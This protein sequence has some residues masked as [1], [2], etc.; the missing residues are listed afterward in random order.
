MGD[1]NL[2]SSVKKN[3]ITPFEK[4]EKIEDDVFNYDLVT[5]K[6]FTPLWKASKTNLNSGPK[7]ETAKSEIKEELEFEKCILE[8]DKIGIEK[9]FAKW[10]EDLNLN[11][12]LEGSMEDIEIP[13]TSS[14]D[15]FA[16]SADYLNKNNNS[17]SSQ[18]VLQATSPKLVISTKRVMLQRNISLE[19]GKSTGNKVNLQHL[20]SKHKNILRNRKNNYRSAPT[21]PT[22]KKKYNTIPSKG[23][24][25]LE[26]QSTITNHRSLQRGNRSTNRSSSLSKK[27]S[28]ETFLSN[29]HS[30]STYNT[31]G[32]K[33]SSMRSLQ[34]GGANRRSGGSNLSLISIDSENYEDE[35]KDYRENA[36]RGRK[37]DVKIAQLEKERLQNIVNMC[38]SLMDNTELKDSENA[39]EFKKPMPPAKPARKS[40]SKL[41]INFGEAN[42]NNHFISTNPSNKPPISPNSAKFTKN[43]SVSPV[44]SMNSQLRRLQSFEDEV[45][46][47]S[48]VTSSIFVDGI[49]ELD[50]KGVQKKTYQSPLNRRQADI[51]EIL[52]LRDENTKKLKSTQKDILQQ[53]ELI[54]ESV[55]E[56]GMEKELLTAELN[57]EH[58]LLQKEELS[59]EKIKDKIMHQ[60]EKYHEQRAKQQE[61]VSKEKN[62]LLEI[63]SNVSSIKKQIDKC[64]ESTRGS[65]EDKLNQEEETLREKTTNF[66]DLEFQALEICSKLDESH[67]DQE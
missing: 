10:F 43:S 53:E 46:K 12:A 54:S 36:R 15:I 32:F 37:N 3:N 50:A 20:R 61:I 29:N 60:A 51:E 55:R 52:R 11:S 24:K 19:S 18:Q 45:I 8:N 23:E 6:L 62:R 63:E 67:Q 5:D 22:T 57:D 30:D 4:T 64:P 28:H 17:A 59:C 56:N 49:H 38:A 16:C 42:K 39:S 34:L 44:S 31:L 35:L 21:S 7:V 2:T 66:E 40:I 47:D 14:A 26:L 41:N 33:A 1:T 27:N 25:P 65:M 9:N 13:T 58:K 48:V